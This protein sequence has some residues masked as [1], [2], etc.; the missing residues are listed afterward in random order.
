MAKDS[1]SQK[2]IGKNNAPRV[3]IEYDVELYGSHK[4]IELPFV[5]GVMSDLSGD[6]KKALLPVEER[7]FLTFDQD[8]FNDR[9]RAIRPH[10]QYYVK[11]TLTDG[12]ELLD[13]DLE[14]E[15]MDDFSPAQIARR[16]PQMAALLEAREHLTQLIT[17]MDG[18]SSA[19]E[20]VK[21][22]LEQPDF[23][24]RLVNDAKQAV[25]SF[26]EDSASENKEV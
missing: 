17:Y 10:L 22:L 23:L 3:Q 6:R 16:I 4:K 20:V 24:Q 14:F 13:V 11:N 15:S 2:F 8:N 25:Q 18:K 21:N 7:K 5:T 1:S 12:D 26:N 19:E 9:M